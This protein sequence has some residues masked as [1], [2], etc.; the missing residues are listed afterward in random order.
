[1]SA[2]RLLPW[3][4]HEA[5]EYLAGVFLVAAPFVFGFTDE[6][7]LPVYVA[8]GVAVL[9]V[10]AL[11]KGS[12]SVAGVLPTSAH[13]VLDYA[14]GVLLVLAPFVFGYRDV[15][16][17]MTISILLGLAH[18]VITL[19]TRFPEQPTAGTTTTDAPSSEGGA[20]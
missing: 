7:A 1:M 4:V 10:A 5:V 3:V 16:T 8:I 12:L 2:V 14:V 6:V 20:G 19:V 13:A 18:L 17:A 11:S 15:D 9:A